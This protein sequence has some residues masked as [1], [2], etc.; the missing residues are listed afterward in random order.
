MHGTRSTHGRHEKY[1]QNV[2]WDVWWV[3][4]FGGRLMFT[5]KINND[6]EAV[7][8]GIKTSTYSNIYQQDATSHSLSYLETVIHV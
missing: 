7:S 1:L 2:Y 5:S 6:K 3:P 8:F 4:R